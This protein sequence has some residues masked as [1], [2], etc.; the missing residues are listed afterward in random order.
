MFTN[1][2]TS[3][4]HALHRLFFQNITNITDTSFLG[5]HE[6]TSIAPTFTN[7]FESESYKRGAVFVTFFVAALFIYSVV[8]IC[9]TGNLLTIRYTL[10]PQQRKHC[11]NLYVCAMAIVDVL[12]GNGILL[13]EMYELIALVCNKHLS[14]SVSAIWCHIKVYRFFDFFR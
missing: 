5:F 3:S 2:E 12:L 10:T 14:D 1:M 4:T 9:G 6:S 8:F 7:D 11:L 13:M